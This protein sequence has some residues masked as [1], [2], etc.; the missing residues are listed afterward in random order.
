MIISFS[1]YAKSGKDTAAEIIALNYSQ[2]RIKKFSG[3]LKQVASILTGIPA[4]LFENHNVKEKYIS[5]WDMTA[6]ELLQKLGTDAVRNNLHKDAWVMSLFAD[7]HQNDSWIITDCRFPNEFDY[8]KK[9]GGITIKII[10]NGVYA[11][12]S[13]ASETALDSYT[14]DEIIENNGTITEFRENVINVINKYIQNE[15]EIN[16]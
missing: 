8:V 12:N 9:F 5:G 1:G 3:K 16:I 7:Y 14:F 13:H 4:E 11:V 2:F 6:R 10:R 15:S